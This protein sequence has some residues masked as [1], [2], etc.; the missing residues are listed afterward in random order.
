MS[1][2]TLNLNNKDKPNEQYDAKSSFSAGRTSFMSNST[3][4]D[5]SFE[6]RD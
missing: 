2:R 5:I 1:N 3:V 6:A 4:R